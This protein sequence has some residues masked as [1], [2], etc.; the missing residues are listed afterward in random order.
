MTYP[1]PDANPENDVF[2][3]ALYDYFHGV[4]EAP[5][6]L[7][8]DYGDPEEVPPEAFFGDV[9][10]FSTTEVYALSLCKGRVLD[11][12]AAGGRHTAFLQK[13]G[14]N[15]Y[16]LDISPYCC[17]IMKETGLQ[18]IVQQ[19]IMYYADQKFDTL[20]MLMNG[21][22]IAGDPDGL[23]AL[24]R[25]L[26]SIVNP[27]AQVL[28][29]SS[30]ISYLYESLDNKLRHQDGVIR[31]RYSYHLMH[32]QWFDWLYAPESLLKKVCKAAGWKMQ[33]ICRD[34]QDQF[35]VRLVE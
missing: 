7:Y 15:T 11:I 30:D 25:H 24:L 35:L 4:F 8:N 5:L 14:L 6:L 3:K 16:A 21:I 32:S 10:D 17:R 18:N 34:D 27:G 9:E 29:D 19:N 28:F 12:G 31:Y 33:V 22:G 26:K 2:G 1:E 13:N 20:L 23:L